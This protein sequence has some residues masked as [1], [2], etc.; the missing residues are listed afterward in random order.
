MSTQPLP[1]VDDIA[2]ITE[3]ETH[4]DAIMIDVSWIP[5][6]ILE[7][8][9]LWGTKFWKLNTTLASVEISMRQVTKQSMN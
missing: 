2:V 4:E 6:N 9:L 5:D 3:L 7:K 8:A 1:L